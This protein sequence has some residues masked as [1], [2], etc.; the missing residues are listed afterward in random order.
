MRYLFTYIFLLSV[1][2]I[3]LKSQTDSAKIK[4]NLRF[5]GQMSG[6]GQFAPDIE[7]KFWLGGRYIPQ[8]NYGIQLPEKGLFD[9]EVSANIFGDIGSE[10]FRKFD[11]AGKIKPYRAWGRY[12]TNQMEI[13]LGLQKIN[14]G[15]AQMFRPLMWFD[16]LDPR[17]PLQ[18]T[19]GVWGGLFR[20][21]FKNNANLWFWTLYGNTD[22]KGWEIVNTVQQIP[23]LGGRIQY[24][25]PK[26]EVA[27]SY[28][29]RKA[30]FPE[31]SLSETENVHR[32]IPE[33]RLGLDIRLDRFVGMWLEASC[34][35]LHKNAGQLTNQEMITLGADYTFGIG[36]G[37]GATFEQL[38][39]SFDEKAFA[40]N[41]IT[42]F[43]G[44]LLTYPLTVFDDIST[45]F[46]YDWDNQN[47]YSFLNWK[48]Q[49]NTIAFHLMLYWNPRTIGIPSQ[50]GSE[51]FIGKG[52]Q[53][54][55]VWNH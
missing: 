17:D 34:T 47:M 54:M 40:F 12:S 9:F 1:V 29:F 31:I 36:N 23:E 6:W 42:T 14:F 10:S 33:S 20:Y 44:L 21:Y 55:V 41:N 53:L 28:H 8:L 24:P 30:D 5:S 25:I 16:A 19:N 27:L 32:E 46:Y 13:R 4:H 48:H 45:I 38:I 26:G 11:A 43:S 50:M 7:T 51:R 52:F 37:L 18:L 15:S 39:Y 2:S 35:Q 22:K 3:S 49:L